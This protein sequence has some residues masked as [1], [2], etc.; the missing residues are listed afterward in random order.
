MAKI[1]AKGDSYY[2]KIAVNYQKRRARQ[3]WWGVEQAEMQSLLKALPKGL[4]VLDVPFGTG[5]F[6]HD[7]R[8][9]DYSIFGVDA[10][11]DMLAAAET[12]LGPAFADCQTQT[13]SAMA[14]PFKDQSFDLVS[15]VRFIRD[16]INKPDA[17]QAMR[18]FARVT[19]RYAIIQLGE[20]SSEGASSHRELS[21]ATPL[22]S[23][24][25]AAGNAA[26]LAEIGFSI[27][28]KRLVKHDPDEGSA[29]YHVLLEKH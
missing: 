15:S 1:G 10:S 7:Y 4:R 12:E 27:I 26:M 14:L 18:E 2:G 13:G 21:D 19:R 17:L 5:R 9:R 3:S 11:N 6:V 28:D 20:H 24:L 22:H 16:I 29:V 23:Q 25:S 8:A